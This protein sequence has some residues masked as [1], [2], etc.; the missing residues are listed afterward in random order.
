MKKYKIKIEKKYK[1]D[2]EIINKKIDN[3]INEIEY[4]Y[5]KNYILYDNECLLY[6]LENEN[7]KD[8]EIKETIKEMI[9]ENVL[10]INFNEKKILY[11]DLLNYKYDIDIK[12][13]NY[14]NYINNDNL[15]IKLIN[16]I[17]ENINIFY[18]FILYL[19]IK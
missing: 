7:I 1:K 14:L 11:N 6:K 9:K 13:I 2:Y 3:I 10:N 19:Y 18:E 15:N 8:N 12:N 16:L 5:L 17:F 4:K